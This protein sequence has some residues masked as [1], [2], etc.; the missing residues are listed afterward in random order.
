M[1]NSVVIVAAWPGRR[2]IFWDILGQDI[3]GQDILGDI[4]G[5]SKN[6]RYFGSE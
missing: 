5:Q 2:G 3:L 4:L 1:S 6:Y